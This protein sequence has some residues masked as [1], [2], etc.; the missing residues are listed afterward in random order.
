MQTTVSEAVLTGTVR[1]YPGCRMH[2]RKSSEDTNNSVAVVDIIS[3]PGAEPPRHVHQFEDELIL[4][5]K[6]EAIFY[7]GD[8]IIAAKP[9]DVLFMPRGVPHHF[10]ILSEKA[11]ISLVLTPGGFERFF[12]A[13]TKPYDGDTAPPLE[14]EPTTEEISYF[15]AV[16]ESFGVTFV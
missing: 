5:K 10:K 11:L 13:I 14:G 9:G 2:F 4:V 15:V 8:E 1:A 16:S 6:G 12:E 7:I 3:T